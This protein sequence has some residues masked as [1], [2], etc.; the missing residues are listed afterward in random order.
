M[1]K[2]RYF[3]K[4]Q[5]IIAIT[6][7]S[8]MLVSFILYIIMV[9]TGTKIYDENGILTGITYNNVIQNIFAIFFLMQLIA[10]VWFIARSITYKMRV[11]E[12]DI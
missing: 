9:F 1:N 6:G 7:L 5:L 2:T 8:A 12:E 10:M 11:K 4:C 3:D